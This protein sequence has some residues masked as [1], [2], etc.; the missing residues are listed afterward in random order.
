[1]A[2]KGCCTANYKAVGR[3]EEALH[4]TKGKSWPSNVDC[5]GG[6]VTESLESTYEVVRAQDCSSSQ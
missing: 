5:G 4:V 3:K 2:G 6:L 1:M